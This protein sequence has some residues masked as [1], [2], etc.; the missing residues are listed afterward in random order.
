MGVAVRQQGDHGRAARL[1][2]QCLRLTRL[3]DEPLTAAVALE[4]LAWIAAEQDKAQGA[5]VL[6][7]AAEALG[8]SAGSSPVLF[9][10]LLAHHENCERQARR[11]LGERAFEAARREGA[12]LG[13]E[14]AV[15]HSLGEHPAA[16]APPAGHTSLT[17]RERQVADLVAEGLT[18]K[19]IATRLVISQRTAQGHVQRILTK[20]GFTSRAQIAAW[21]VEHAQDERARGSPAHSS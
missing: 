18:D 3:A 2:E 15:A 20:L 13:F 1:L 8:R 7:G 5:A 21:V 14:Q 10:N 6:L 17:N 19:A 12:A 9:H 16:A 11:A 4:A